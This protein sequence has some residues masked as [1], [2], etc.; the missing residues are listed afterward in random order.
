MITRTGHIEFSRYMALEK[1]HGSDKALAIINEVTA[2]L[3][4]EGYLYNETHTDSQI[5]KRSDQV[6]S[7]VLE[8][9]EDDEI[10]YK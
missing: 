6:Y 1:I 3:E 10:P 4:N 2:R 7:E 9:W 8:D 5:R